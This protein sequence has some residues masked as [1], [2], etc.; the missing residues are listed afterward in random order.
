M[1]GERRDYLVAFVI[2][3][4]VGV[5]ATMLLSAPR[6]KKKAFRSFPPALQR[7]RKRG[8]RLRKLGPRR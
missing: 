2:G 5:G 8:R 6:K 7:F 1:A 3:A 4:V